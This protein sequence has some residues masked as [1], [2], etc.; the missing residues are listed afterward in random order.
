[1]TEQAEDQAPA[2][3]AP[4]ENFTITTSDYGPPP[5]PEKKA[6]PEDKG[7]AD[8]VEDDDQDAPE[9]DDD[10]DDLDDG[11]LPKGAVK[12]LARE[13]RKRSEALAAVRE[14]EAR[15][16]ELERRIAELEA[17]QAGKSEPEEEPDPDDFDT[18]DEYTAAKRKW[19]AGRAKAKDAG[20]KGE[21]Q[22]KEVQGV[23]VAD[24]DRAREEVR[25]IIEDEDPDV[26]EQMVSDEKLP[27]S[28]GVVV[29][30]SMADD[31]VALAKHFL[32]N[33]GELE[34][35]SKMSPKRAQTAITK[36]ELRLALGEP[37]P[38]KVEDRPKADPGKVPPDPIKPV[39]GRAPTIEDANKALA[40]GDFKTFERLRNEAERNRS[41]SW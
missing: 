30:M 27:F 18:W 16:E 17:R 21:D 4:K 22:P 7:A 3:E 26:W 28:P 13:K 39:K 14:A 20:K 35:I 25:S 10:D 31:P 33:R 37:A 12:R 2:E 11:K 5:E 24:L 38:K 41:S 23:P 36:L 19:D 1:M 6:K 15:A 40:R 34:R 32:E 8:D 9:G 29:A